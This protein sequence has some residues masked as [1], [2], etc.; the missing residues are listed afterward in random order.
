MARDSLRV[1]LGLPHVVDDDKG[2]VDGN[3]PIHGRRCE[4][5][6]NHSEEPLP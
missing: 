1:E 2:D 6:D 5:G 4:H 3:D